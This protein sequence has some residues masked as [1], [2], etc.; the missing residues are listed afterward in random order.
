MREKGVGQKRN[1]PPQPTCNADMFWFFVGWEGSFFSHKK[2]IFGNNVIHPPCVTPSYMYFSPLVY[3]WC[4][5]YVSPG[6]SS[7][8]LLGRSCQA[9]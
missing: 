4:F 7:L 3:P 9:I 8:K 1:S 6:I 5:V 2:V